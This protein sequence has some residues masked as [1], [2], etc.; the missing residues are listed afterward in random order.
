M[1]KAVIVAIV[2]ALIMCGCTYNK[3][4]I[5]NDDQDG[6]M[7][8]IFND[9]FA[10]IYRDNKTGVQYFSRTDGGSCVMVDADGKPFVLMED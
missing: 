7:S 1:K 3:H 6:R 2:C 4:M 8:V 9:G 10:I 5:D